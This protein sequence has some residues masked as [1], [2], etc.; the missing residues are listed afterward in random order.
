MIFFVPIAEAL[1]RLAGQVAAQHAISRRPEEYRRR[2]ERIL[3][4]EGTADRNAPDWAPRLERE[5]QPR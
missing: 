4:Q 1:G 2:I 3:R 5:K